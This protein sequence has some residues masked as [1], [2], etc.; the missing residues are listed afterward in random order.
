[1]KKMLKMTATSLLVSGMA[2]GVPLSAAGGSV[3]TSTE[4]NLRF[5]LQHR[6]N[7]SQP[8]PPETITIVSEEFA[9]NPLVFL[10]TLKKNFSKH[11]EQQS[12]PVQVSTELE[13][14]L[15]KREQE[16]LDK[17]PTVSIET[18]I[19]KDGV[20][21]SK[22][23]FPAFRREVPKTCGKGGA[24]DWK[25]LDGQFSFTDQFENLT[26]ALNVAGLI[27]EEEGVFGLSL[28]K[29]TLNGVLDSHFMPIKMDF[30]LSSLK[31]GG[32]ADHQL[33][34]QQVIFKLNVEKTPKGVNINNANFN[35]GH[36][37]LSRLRAKLSFDGLAVA[38]S[39]EEQ[40]GGINYTV[41]TQ[42]GQSVL[43]AMRRLKEGLEVS[44][45]GKLVFKRIDEEAFLAL[46]TTARELFKQQYHPMLLMVML[47][48][49]MQVAPKLV[50]KS[51]ELVLNPLVLKTSKGDLQGQLNVSLDGKQVTSLTTNALIGALQAQA[52]FTIGNELL[53]LIDDIFKMG[54][55][56]ALLVDAGDG[57]SKLVATLKGRQL[58]INGMAIPL[59]GAPPRH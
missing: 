1:M 4:D 53:K 44:H 12:K 8:L 2:L 59:F 5:T 51:P 48:Q 58:I 26:A 54:V 34:L 56:K 7:G 23:V 16:C 37:N 33:E 17:L 36:L 11:L 9:K 47:N 28:G 15:S 49:V 52:D 29:T 30:N 57:N 19:D 10:E 31:A 14:L 6:F 38:T 35:V 13:F 45:E 24:L 46:Q 50:A 21:Q 27:V 3:T 39:G 40:D 18:Q 22:V 25:G 41:Q 32:D 42:L 43:P 55:I 20:G